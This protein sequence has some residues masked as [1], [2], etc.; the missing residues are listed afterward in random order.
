VPLNL[1][2]RPARARSLPAGTAGCRATARRGARP[3]GGRGHPIG[4][5]GRPGGAGS[6]AGSGSGAPESRSGAQAPRQGRGHRVPMSRS[7][8]RLGSPLP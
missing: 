8:G 1:V 3:M 5:F 6:S 2:D 4:G 7:A